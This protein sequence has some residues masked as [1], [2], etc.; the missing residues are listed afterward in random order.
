ML[1]LH[2]VRSQCLLQ[3]HF[4]KEERF[5]IKNAIDKYSSTRKTANTIK[6]IKTILTCLDIFKYKHSV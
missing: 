4:C 5:D 1:Y 3:N 6:I 2:I